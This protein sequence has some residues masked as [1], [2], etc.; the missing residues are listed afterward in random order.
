MKHSRRALLTASLGLGQ[1]LLLDR[2]GLVRD[3]HA[4]GEPDRP[5]RLLVL[6]LQGGYRMQTFFVPPATEAEVATFIPP[7]QGDYRQ[8]P[9]YFN[10]SDVFD[11]AP[12]A[13]GYPA[14]RMG[15]TWNP[16][17][18]KDRKD[19]THTP[20]GYGWVHYGLADRTTVIHGVDNVAFDHS[21]AYVSAMCGVPGASY[22]APAF[23]SIVANYLQRQFA[24][25]RPLPCVAIRANGAPNPL[26]LP[27][28]AAPIL[29]Q[30]FDGLAT[31]FSADPAVVS[32]WKGHSDRS[33]VDLPPFAGDAA[34]RSTPMTDLERFTAA[35]T[36]QLR[37][38]STAGTDAYLGQIYDGYAQTSST[39]ARDV[40]KV[41]QNTKGVEAPKPDYASGYGPFGVTFGNANGGPDLADSAEK[42]LRLL[43]S[44]LT[45][46]VYAFLNEIYF[47][48]HNGQLGN[49][50]GSA[51][52]RGEMDAIARILGQMKATPAPG[53][54]GKTLYEDTLVVI[55]SEFGR[56]WPQG[57][58][59]SSFDGWTFPDDHFNYTSVVLSGG[60]A[61]PNRQ[62]GGF[63]LA[64]NVAGRPV[65][66]R[67]ESGQ[68]SQRIPRSADVVATICDA[69]GMK[70]G[71]DF[72]IPGGY[73][74]IE[75]ATV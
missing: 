1:F 31:Y 14:L 42:V 11:L 40:V 12:A 57:K 21:G 32:W 7:H 50:A 39:L 72:F 46:V 58:D 26:T 43:K 4:G 13:G 48:T 66:I 59:Q 61:A 2:F 17:D 74:V 37:G 63:D 18:P 71:D 22:R 20:A 27:S 41:L 51:N 16:A 10:A 15:R 73:G 24:D 35:R 38:R 30:S 47:D 56:G 60:N 54:P 52:L 67:E 19:F 36:R 68:T 28:A 69:F 5:S 8:E 25:T 45:S 9:V 6:Y 55:L 33:P 23:V 62:I 34:P 64:P 49:M 70:M 75:G 44:D 53:R 29:I 65:A 3:A